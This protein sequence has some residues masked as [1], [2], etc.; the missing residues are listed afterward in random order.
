MQKFRLIATAASGIEAL[1][2]RELRDLGYQVQTENGRVRFNGTIKDILRTNLWLRTADRIKI[3]V[4][5]FDAYTF[6]E[7]FEKT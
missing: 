3:I 6:D 7:L 1:V 5:E 4:G 2:G